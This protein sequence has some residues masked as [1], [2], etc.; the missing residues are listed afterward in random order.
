MLFPVAWAMASISAT[1]N[2]Y[3]VGAVSRRCMVADGIPDLMA[4]AWT[5]LPLLSIA[6]RT[7]LATA[8]G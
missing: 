7:A 1:V 2:G 3:R 5:L 6:L 8:S 4:V